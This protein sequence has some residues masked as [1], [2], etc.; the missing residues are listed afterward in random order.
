MSI[1]ASEFNGGGKAE[2][3]AQSE[4]EATPEAKPEAVNVETAKPDEGASDDDALGDAGKKALHAEREARKE[5]EK[6][7]KEL[8][9]RVKEFEDRDKTEQERAQEHLERLTGDLDATRASLAAAELNLARVEVAHAK[10]IPAELVPRL[11][12]ETREE[13]EAD[14]DAL[15]EIVGKREAE[16]PRKPKP[17]GSLGTGGDAR[18]TPQEQFAAIM[19]QAL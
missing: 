7:L 2:S 10:G 11:R 14:A 6:R 8:D 3:G 16:A 13:L 9:A 17:V 1:S 12:G 5:A 19:Q 15:L 18:L 4:A